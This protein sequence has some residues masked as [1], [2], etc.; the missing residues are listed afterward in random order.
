M[1][2]VDGS[3]LADA[4]GCSLADP[5]GSG[6]REAGALCDADAAGSC[7][8]HALKIATRSA[9]VGQRRRDIPRTLHGA[10]GREGHHRFRESA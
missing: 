10:I 2:T 8:E 9:T 7:A 4:G 1:V 6:S 5:D 3:A